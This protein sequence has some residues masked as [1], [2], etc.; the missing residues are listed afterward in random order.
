VEG[1][2]HKVFKV[3]RLYQPSVIFVG[4]A[5]SIF[6]KKPKDDPWDCTRMKK[7]LPTEVKS[8]KPG[9]R[10]VVIGTEN[11]PYEADIKALQ[12]VF[13]K[14]LM[15]PRPDYGSRRRLWEQI[16]TANGGI[17][18]PSLDL[19]S[20]AKISGAC[21]HAIVPDARQP[22]CGQVVVSWLLQSRA[23]SHHPCHPRHTADPTQTVTRP[24]TLYR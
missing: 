22:L 20:L 1:M 18:T 7:E 11:C 5:C 19:S 12:T 3:A 2:L 10:V 24:P 23:A 14:I 21:Q 8:L 17:T 9:D 13:Q 15:V 4:A 16:L 6:S